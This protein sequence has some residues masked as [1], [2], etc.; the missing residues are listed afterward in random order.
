LTRQHALKRS[1]Q[2]SKCAQWMASS[3]RQHRHHR[4]V[5]RHLSKQSDAMTGSSGQTSSNCFLLQAPTNIARLVKPAV[6][7]TS[8]VR[9]FLDMMFRPDIL[10]ST[11]SK[12]SR[13]SEAIDKPED[14]H[15]RAHAMRLQACNAAHGPEPYSK[16]KRSGIFGR[17]RALATAAQWRP[18]NRKIW[19]A[20]GDGDRGEGE[21]MRRETISTDVIFA[22]LQP[23][24]ENMR[25]QS[26]CAFV[27]LLHRGRAWM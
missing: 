5:T 15:D 4:P 25:G 12:T 26:N 9:T 21:A 27:F 10:R 18:G 1:K 11:R 17:A 19:N 22:R 3:A 7:H 8:M 20:N 2:P 6:R 14:E 16:K 13:H 24:A 23:S